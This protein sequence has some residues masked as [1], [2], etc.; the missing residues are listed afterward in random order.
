MTERQWIEAVWWL[1]ILLAFVGPLVV[2]GAVF[3][4]KE[5]HW[6][7]PRDPV[8]RLHKLEAGRKAQARERGNG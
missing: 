5:R 3:E 2:V 6:R 8:K 4:W 1:A 7:S